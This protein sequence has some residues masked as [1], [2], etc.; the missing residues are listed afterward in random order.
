MKKNTIIRTV[1]TLGIASAL[2]L[3]APLAASAHVHVTPDQA[4]AGSYAVL[5]FRV[6]T[7]SATASTVKL[8]VDFPT[9][10][11]FSTVSYQPITGWQAVVTTVKLATP[12]KTATATITEA[13]SKVVWTADAAS[14]IA[15]GQFQQFSVSAGPVP[16]TGS[17][18]LPAHQTYSDGTV[19]DWN[20]PTPASGSEP[21]HPAPTLYINDAPPAA[22]DADAVATVS[23]TPTAAPTNV[24]SGVS[25]S[26]D[27]QSAGVWVGLGGLL[28]GAIALVVAMLALTR[29]GRL[30]KQ[31]VGSSE[32]GG[33]SERGDRT[34]GD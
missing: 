31:A 11:P 18:M 27:V 24:A 33:A 20:Q 23:T 13:V 12:V 32:P 2:A 14:A 15:P 21:Q 9:T 17:V 22:S 19:V 28:L 29:Q 25:G 1:T 6:P 26:N 30:A 10:T 4:A 5:T 16:D 34:K 8:E 7:E 3:A